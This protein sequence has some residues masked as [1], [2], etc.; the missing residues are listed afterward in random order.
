[1]ELHAV[2]PGQILVANGLT[3]LLGVIA[4][5]LLWP[6]TNA[7]TSA[8]SFISYP[9][10]THA[11]GAQ[12]VETPLHAGGYDLDALLAAINPDTRVVFLANPTNPTGTL[13]EAEAVDRFLERVPPHAIVV[14]DEAYFDYAHYFAAQ[15]QVEHSR[16]LDYV[17]R[18]RN[19]V[20]LRTFSKAHGLAAVR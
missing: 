6:G 12:L 15:R 13:L 10:V 19:V 16:S 2:G 8:C 17:H 18:N 14:L 20:V 1:A 5:T 4:R 9:M 7:V 11:A 3:A